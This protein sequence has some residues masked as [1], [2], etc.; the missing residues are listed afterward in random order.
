MLDRAPW[1]PST[2]YPY[3]VPSREWKCKIGEVFAMRR[4]DSR[5]DIR[6]RP[7]G[8]VDGGNVIRRLPIAGVVRRGDWIGGVV[9]C[10]LLTWDRAGAAG[11]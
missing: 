8:M 9:G 1:V 7:G 6:R 10:S 2:S 3:T 11:V 4:G 5:G